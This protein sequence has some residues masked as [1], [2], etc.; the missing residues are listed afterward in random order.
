MHQNLGKPIAGIAI[1]QWRTAPSCVCGW[2]VMVH[3][4]GLHACRCRV[5]VGNLDWKITQAELKTHMEQDA[6]RVW[7]SPL[8]LIVNSLARLA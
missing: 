6:G 7:T 5:F 3:S 2:I 8:N 1:D 4:G